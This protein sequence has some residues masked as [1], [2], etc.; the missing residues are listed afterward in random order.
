MANYLGTKHEKIIIDTNQLT[1]ALFKSV[2]ARDLPGMAD[3]DASLLLFC[4]EV[5]KHSTVALSGECADEIFGGYP[6][7]RDEKI[8]N[9]NNFPWSKSTDYRVSFLKD[10]IVRGINPEKYVIDKYNKTLAQTSK[11]R[12]LSKLESRMKEMVN[13]NL[14]WFMQTLLEIKVKNC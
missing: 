9:E 6:W 10:E 12:N 13:L 8:R 5:K 4:K 11:I 3:V 14:N 1:D 2:D 7:Y